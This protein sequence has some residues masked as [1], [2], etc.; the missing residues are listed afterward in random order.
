MLTDNPIINSAYEEPTRYW[1]YEAG[2]PVLREG[3]RTAGYYLKARTHPAQMALLEEEFVPLELVNA[4]RERVRAWR[5]RGYPN[6]PLTRQLL[7][8]WNRPE[9]ERK[10][11]F[12][13]RE[14]I[15]TLI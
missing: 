1:D 9:R 2:Q 3:R 5:E 4:I 10:L 15:E 12:C 6:V 11:F 7:S 8:R 14:A 13:Q